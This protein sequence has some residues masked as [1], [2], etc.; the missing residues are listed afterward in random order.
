MSHRS[1]AAASQKRR[2]SRWRHQGP[3]NEERAVSHQSTAPTPQTYLTRARL[4]Q[5]CPRDHERAFSHQS[6][7]SA[8]REC[9]TRARLRYQCPRD[10]ECSVSQ[11][12]TAA[13]SQK[14][15]SRQAGPE[16]IGA[17][18]RVCTH[19][20][21]KNLPYRTALCGICGLVRRNNVAP[22][23]SAMYV[24]CRIGWGMCWSGVAMPLRS[25]QSGDDALY[26]MSLVVFIS[27]RPLPSS[28]AATTQRMV[29]VYNMHRNRKKQ[30]IFMPLGRGWRGNWHQ[31]APERCPMRARSVQAGTSAQS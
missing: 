18:G 15:H 4:R 23:R 16:P 29:C 27:A 10:H 24:G 21:S 9:F 28:R 14:L 13:A 19:V 7:A 1:T 31:P 30:R 20:N 8:S 25:K 2:F 6:T 26:V 11:Q 17:H 22:C 5:Q 3:R 12:G